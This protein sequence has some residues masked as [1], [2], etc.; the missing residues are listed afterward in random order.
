M[1]FSARFDAFG[2]ASL[3]VDVELNVFL[4]YI[5][6]MCFGQ[7]TVQMN[8]DVLPCTSIKSVLEQHGAAHAQSV[9]IH[10]SRLS[11][12]PL[13]DRVNVEGLEELVTGFCLV[14][15]QTSN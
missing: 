13:T 15:C 8:T 12:K 2:A 10:G 1:Y 7:S 4:S 11:G 9:D 14:P 5:S 6:T 3:N